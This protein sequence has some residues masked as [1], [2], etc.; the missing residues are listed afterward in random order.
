MQSHLESQTIMLRSNERA[1]IRREVVGWWLAEA[2]GTAELRNCY[3]YYV[4]QLADGSRIFLDRPTRLNKGMDFMIKCENY[5]V[6]KNGNCKPPSHANMAAL[7]NDL[8]KDK[9]LGP[10]RKDELRLA[11]RDIWNCKEPDE[12]LSEF[13]RLRTN[14]KS[15]RLLKLVRWFFIEQDLTYWTESG[16]W[17]LRAYLES[18]VGDLG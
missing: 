2:P 8:L 7:L 6:Y 13:A 4:E 15:E 11:L 10:S 3:R 12:V 14:S 9:T 18:F 1:K 16:R 5:I 17:K